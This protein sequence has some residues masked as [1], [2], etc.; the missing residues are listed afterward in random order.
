MVISGTVKTITHHNPENGYSILKVIAPGSPKP[1]TV[2]GFVGAIAVGESI[3]AEGK[4]VVN[5]DYGP[6]LEAASITGTPP[7]TLE[8]LVKYLGSGAFKGIGKT[9]AEKLVAAFGMDTIKVLETHPERLLTVPGIKAKLYER[10]TTAF[11]SGSAKRT[12][13]VFLA[14]HGVS[15][16]IANKILKAYG[17]NAVS[18]VSANPYALARDIDGVGFETADR[19]ARHLGFSADSPFR[20]SAG[21][22]HLVK[23]HEREGHCAFPES[24][25]KSE[26]K[27]LLSVDPSKIV[28]TL[29]KELTE[30][31]LVRDKIDGQPCIFRSTLFRAEVAVA[32]SL[33]RLTNGRL[34][35]GT[36][37][38]SEQISRSEQAL[39]L[40]LGK[41]QKKAVT[42]ALTSKVS[43]I[44]GGPGTG[45]STLTK[46]IL[47]VLASK[48]T[49]VTLCS[50]T[51]RAAK[52]LAEITGMDAGTI[53][54]TLGHDPK[55]GGFKYSRSN[56]LPT[57]LV[58][59]DE[60]SM[61]A[62]DLMRDLLDAIPDSAALLII[63]DVDQ[64]PSVGP[65]CVLSDIID[66]GV[67]PVV[68]LDQVFRQTGGSEIIVAAHEINKGRVP[69][70]S[71]RENSDFRFLSA[72]SPEEIATKLV[73]VVRHQI[74]KKYGLDPLR[75]VQ[76]LV[77]MHKGILGTA[78]LNV[79]L[80]AALNPGRKDSVK[81]AGF[82]FKT[83]DKVMVVE[84]NYDKGVFNGDVGFL[85]RIDAD[86]EECT[87]RFEDREVVYEFSELDEILPA[88]AM[89][90]HKSQGCEY[91][92]VVIPVSMEQRGMLQRNLLY[93][94]VTRGKRLVVLIGESE[95][96]ATAVKNISARQRWTNLTARLRDTLKGPGTPISCF[97]VAN[98]LDGGLVP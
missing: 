71:R 33:A 26:A 74:A 63:G 53:H 80:Q 21:I 40:S 16:S 98:E 84:N 13:L 86:L 73:D 48:G 85:N 32:E 38:L 88:Y 7:H 95:A 78:N 24:R 45:K 68:R 42:S 96:I 59:L 43:V 44:T 92:A 14:S 19:I 20:L 10:I 31:Y 77:P 76:V 62:V 18:R 79:Q 22:H 1:V 25:L 35:W 60:A 9:Y 49:H 30:G 83:E 90:I 17:S 12:I 47:N 5:K 64:L 29:E 36:V 34:P 65:G 93:T 27:E 28:S 87:I 50:F 97:P 8:G 15:V 72:G 57:N 69:D 41:M 37:S 70:L 54:R 6:Q 11:A 91:P 39:S 75:E 82:T 89:T 58:L 81:R 61:T 56:P 46:A 23:G 67:V 66:S 52:R 4:W 3:N 2:V 55:T 94:G 51:G